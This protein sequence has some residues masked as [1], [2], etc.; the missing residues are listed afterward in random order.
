[1]KASARAIVDGC[2]CQTCADRGDECDYGAEP[3]HDECSFCERGR[4]VREREIE[5]EREAEG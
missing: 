3:G 5:D 1:M 2:I 4:H